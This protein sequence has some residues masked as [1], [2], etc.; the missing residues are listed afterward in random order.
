[1]KIWIFMHPKRTYRGAYT[2]I[3]SRKVPGSVFDKFVSIGS[4]LGNLGFTLRSGGADG[5]DTAFE[6]GCDLVGGR[7]EIYLPWSGFNGNGSRL[8]NICSEAFDVASKYHPSWYYLRDS[9]KRLHARNVYQV[10]GL[11]LDTPSRFIICYTH[12]GKGGTLQAL[13]IG[14]AYGVPIFNFIDREY[15]VSEML[16]I[17]K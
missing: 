8:Y 13:R 16:D 2:G 15:E 12:W 1:L 7:K 17:I 6:S 10:L 14:K 11:D 5:C 9:V 4:E 3:G